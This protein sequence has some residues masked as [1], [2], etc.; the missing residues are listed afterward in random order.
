[1]PASP[2]KGNI[3]SRIV[4]ARKLR[5]RV[6]ELESRLSSDT[7]NIEVT[8][9]E[10]AMQRVFER[11]RFRLDWCRPRR[12]RLRGRRGGASGADRRVLFRP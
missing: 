6:A 1:M 10:P 11:C 5:Q 2:I 4:N 9:Q 8:T 3:I 7:P 12:W